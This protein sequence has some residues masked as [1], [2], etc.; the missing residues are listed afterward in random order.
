M[1][2]QQRVNLD[3]E[4]VARLCNERDELCQTT[5]RLCSEHGTTHRECDQAVREHDEAQQRIG[6]LQAELRT[7]TTQRLEAEGV[8]IGLV[9]DLTEVRKNL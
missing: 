5:E 2:L 7:V 4:A 1:A 6:S 9:A 8:S 3:A